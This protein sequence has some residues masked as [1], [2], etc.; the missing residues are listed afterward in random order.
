MSKVDKIPKDVNLLTQTDTHHRHGPPLKLVRGGLEDLKWTLLVDGW[1]HPPLPH[2]SCAETRPTSPEGAT[3]KEKEKVSRTTGQPA[4]HGAAKR[5]RLGSLL[6]GKTF[7][8]NSFQCLQVSACRRGIQN[9]P[10]ASP[11]WIDISVSASPAGPIFACFSWG[12]V[13]GEDAGY[14]FAGGSSLSSLS[15]ALWEGVEAGVYKE[16]CQWANENFS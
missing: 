4:P 6:I 5:R 3:E 16:H 1:V 8:T 2:V 12:R 13:C 11:K 9:G 15:P 10:K 14:V 7:T